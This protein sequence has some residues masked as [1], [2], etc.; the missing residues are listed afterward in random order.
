MVKNALRRK[1][2]RDMW[3]NQMQFLAVILLCALGT[4]VFSGL[5]AAWRMIDLSASTYFESQ[6]LADLWVTLQG[7]DRAVLAE[8]R[9]MPG[10][11]DVQARA[12]AELKVDLPHEPSLVLEAYDESIRINK[13]L[14]YEGAAL[15]SRATGCPSSWAKAY[16]S[17]SSAAPA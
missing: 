6:N 13:P 7:M 4:W 17:L 3:K 8:V 5:D 9:A 11:A 15:E 2:F 16:T 10:V 14:M 1:L 12:S